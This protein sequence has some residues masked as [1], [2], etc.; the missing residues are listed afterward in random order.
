MIVTKT[1]RSS[2]DVPPTLRV[3][4]QPMDLLPPPPTEIN[5]EEEGGQLAPEYVD[6]IAGLMKISRD[7]RPLYVKPIDHLDEGVDLSLIENDDGIYE[8]SPSIIEHGSD[9]TKQP[10]PANRIHLTDGETAG[11]YKEIPGIRLHDDPDRDVT[12][13]RFSLE[14]ERTEKQQRI[15]YRINQGPAVGFWVPAKEQSMNIAFYTGNGFASTVD[16]NKVCGPDPL[17]RDILN[18]HQTRP[19]H[20]MIGGGDQV[21]N[22][23]VMLESPL[24]QEW[25]KIKNPG[26]KFSAPLSA[27]FKAELETFLLERYALWFSQGLFSLANSQIPMVNVWNDHELIE[28]FGSYSE[29]FMR[30]PVMMGLGKLAFKY[31]LLFQHH[32]LVEETDADEPSW[33]L[34]AHSGPYIKEKS[35][36]VFM[37]LGKHVAFL[38]LDCRTERTVSIACRDVL[39]LQAV[40]YPLLT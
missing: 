3:F 25:L 2:Y 37:S 23:T 28:G 7:G 13:W 40:L 5:G 39:F 36:N 4:P 16:S 32:S 26:D 30:T 12:F 6:P 29:E 35:R 14:V 38:G 31:Y 33:L 8:Q 1:S 10:I 11:T 18:E 27:E 9:G 21:F 34:G 19:F 20:V 22:D 17:W 15:A 24:F